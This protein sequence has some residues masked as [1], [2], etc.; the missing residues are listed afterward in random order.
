MSFV[1]E[2]SI[3][4]PKRTG[5]RA[6]SSKYPFAQMAVGQSF[7]VGS[8]IKASTVRS[9]IGA[10]CKTNKDFKFAVRVVEDGVR[11]WRVEAEEE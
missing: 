4:V 2:S 3:P 11:V 6:G 1:I 8:D 10:F 5:G 9:A 7:L